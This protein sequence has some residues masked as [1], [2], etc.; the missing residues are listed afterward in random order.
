M[1]QTHI[2][3]KLPFRKSACFVLLLA[4][5]LSASHAGTL[6][7][8]QL[9]TGYALPQEGLLPEVPASPFPQLQATKG[10]NLMSLS[11]SD[12]GSATDLTPE[13]TALAISL[14]SDPYSIFNYVRNK[15]EYQPYWGSHKGA[16]GTYLDGAGNDMDQCSLLIALLNA[17]GYTQTSYVRGNIN[18]PVTTGSLHDLV[19]WYGTS[20][21]LAPVV[22]SAAGIPY[23]SPLVLSG[24]TSFD[25]IW[26]RVVIDGTTYDLDP[27]YK[28]IQQYAGI[29]YK[30]ASGY[31]RAQLLTDAAGTEGADFVQDMNRASVESSLG[32]YAQNLRSY[33]QTNVPSY[34]FEQVVASGTLFEESVGSL[35]AGAPRSGFGP[36]V[37]SVFTTIPDALRGSLHVQTGDLDVTMP[38]DA[39]QARPLALTFSGNNA[40]LWL[41]GTVI[42]E[43]TAGGGPTAMVNINT[44]H[45]VSRLSSSPSGKSYL[46]TGTYDL[47]YAFYPNPKSNGRIEAANRRLAG[48]LAAGLADTS[49]EVLTETL[50]GLGLRWVKRAALGLQMTSRVTNCYGWVD[51]IF[52]RTGQEASFFVDMYGGVSNIFNSEGP[53]LPAFSAQGFLASAMEHGVIE[54]RATSSAL[55]T[56][57]CLALANDGGQK[58]Y[59]ATTNNFSTISPALLA[60]GYTPDDVAWISSYVTAAGS[61]GATLVH[62]NGQ[63][64]TGE[65]LG[66]GFSSLGGSFVSMMIFG[67][68]HGGYFSL[69]GFIL[70]GQFYPLSTLLGY[71]EPF[72][73]AK[74]MSK[75][76]VDL[77]T[78]AYTM[79]STDLSL[80]EA[81]SPRGLAFTRTY[82]SSRNFQPSALGNGWRHSCEG[83][84]IVGSDLD[85]AFGYRQASDAV[86]TIVGVIAAADFSKAAYTAKEQM[87]GIL[88]ANWLVNRITNNSATVQLG[89]HRLSYTSLP[90]GS[91]NSPPGAT[92]TLTGSS[93]SFVLQPRFGGSVSFDAQN[94]VS[95]W[96]DVDDN[97]QTYTYDADGRLET[98]TDSQNRALTFSYFSASSPLIQSVSD[99]TGRTVTY[100]HTGD[101][102]TGIQDVEGYNTTLVYD[103][104][105]LLKDW[106]D[107]AGNFITR[108]NYDSEDRVIQQISQGDVNR[109]W[110]FFYSPGVTR[111]VDPLNY[112]TTHY[113]DSKN[114]PWGIVD[115]RGNAS[116][117]SYDGQNHVIKTVDGSGRQTQFIYDANQN[118]I[119]TTDNATKTTSRIYDG[120]L[121]LW[122]IIDPTSRVTEFGYDSEHHLTSIKDP[123]GRVTQMT[124]NAD[125]RLHLVTDP[126]NKTTAFTSYDQWANPTGVTRADS[127]TTS[128]VF[129]ARGDMTSLTNGRG[130]TIGFTYDNRRLL[131]TR[132]DPLNKVSSWTYDS[133]GRPATATDRNSKTTT[134]V[135]D[136]FGKLQSVAAPDTGTVNFGY[137]LR[138]L[139]TTVSDGLAHTTTTG[140]DAASRPQTVTD[141][142][143]IVVSTV[144]L[145]GAAR[146]TQRKNGLNKTTQ[147]F[148]DSAGRISYM[149][150]P[151]NRR[152]DSTYDD[153]G[154][155]LTLKNRNN[156]TFAY[157]IGSD[158]LP[159]TFT[160]PSGRQSSIVDRDLAGRP[161][162]LQKPGGQQTVLTYDGMGRVKTQADGVGTIT[163]TY[164]V[165]GNPTNVAEGTANIGRT[166][167][168]LGRVLTCTDTAG[169]TVSYTYD[170]EGNLATL[171][172]P[173]NKTVSYTYDGS[174]RLK[175]V[176]D[177]AGRLTTYTWDLGGRL[178]QVDRPNGTRQ[179]LQ[180][181]NANR[182]TD[183][184]EEK[185]ATSIWQAAYG[186]DNAYRL[187]NYTPTPITKTLPPPP[188]TMTYDTDNR[189]Q[190]YNSQTVAN[191]T[192]GNLLSAPVSGTLLGA[193]TW[194]ARNRL[195]SAGEF[196]YAYDAENRRISS[197]ENN[198]LIIYTWSRGGLDRLLVKTNPDGSVTRY[199]H[200]LGLIYE[201]TT[202]SGGGTP[203]PLYYHYN[204]QGS[205]VVLSDASGNV[206]ARI[207]YSPYGE[208][209][210]ESGNVTTPFC[211]N[212]QFG[213]MTESSGL[214]AMQAR[215]YS[216]IFRRFLS[217]DPAGFGGG[218]N[219]YA[220]T[221]GDP[222]NL[223]DPFGLGP[224][225]T[226]EY[227]AGVGQV[228][229][230]YGDA[231]TE[232]VMGLWA[233]VRNPVGT[234]QGL[235]YAGM[236]P[237][238]TVSNIAGAVGR[239][240][241][242]LG[243]GDN[244]LTG[245]SVGRGLILALTVAAPAA[246]ARSLILA[247]SGVPST[248][249]RVVDARFVNSP[250]LGAPGAADVFVTSASDIAG[251]N[252]SQGL[253][254]RLTLLDN[255]GNLRQGPFGVIQFN[256]P[257]S[258]LAS[259]VF[260]NTPGFIQGGL[261][262]GGASEF[263][264]PNFRINQLQNVTTRTIP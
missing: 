45:P 232:T 164:D 26:V 184:I 176:T 112:V 42:A 127:T 108:N 93:G 228:W 30:G 218:I 177:W 128:A 224:S 23:V 10:A 88:S 81:N 233:M 133:N 85:S 105:N 25:H 137:D 1:N 244:R 109:L 98:V 91:W 144:V 221:G 11:L 51:G 229:R 236:H 140:Y 74:D 115:A 102:L 64:G 86:Q 69:R 245:R 5:F 66:Y 173:G 78:G 250:T 15:V 92:T 126:A 241:Q 130:K 61:F 82:D 212:G 89:E 162:T 259:P 193:L 136:N 57:K 253:A 17:A 48:F 237:L 213:V 44:T 143:S 117:I 204:W 181:D 194:D 14:R 62:E 94:R 97:T 104:R 27:S 239:T 192:N 4:G 132:T 80:G 151:L 43:E 63:T 165:E 83:R 7:G 18:V 234:A 256:M 252:T 99:G 24:W 171:T 116:S 219:L 189:L 55:S 67:D 199:I 174:N 52:G 258:G 223:M 188:A 203:A 41:G 170:N 214:L 12:F 32:Q 60:N 39:L 107:H 19:R 8:W 157:G 129:N 9:G 196:A 53:N 211:F 122:K 49:R 142:L 201:E 249:A 216:P 191:D 262:R 71:E 50:H 172:Y 141:P 77:A 75:E 235:Y 103:S 257:A 167:D 111:E 152:V 175:T 195:T 220:Y 118:L 149:L 34:T 95:H 16:H 161:H 226:G 145:D 158:G 120:S 139:Q 135:F 205:T 47:T 2:L 169:N 153:A 255:A 20:S 163:W 160:Y 147:I 248:L 3:A 101:N 240:L 56:V 90:D 197:T 13:L 73:V 33:I 29:D 148:Y 36:T 222:V 206:T 38:T 180:Y 22:I 6:P 202:P 54:E 264:L 125:G 251:I 40:Q 156:Q 150:D 146:V 28:R 87:T 217:E 124:Y 231:G 96:K 210:V 168:D 242:D 21:S 227:I 84:V 106:K 178:T 70:G 238:Q 65:W 119:Y 190:T 263:A 76:P 31:N 254:N 121:R 208:R 179:R 58:I 247:E 225:A 68:Y 110:R 46:R 154:R 182:L 200:G 37:S 260:R 230:G 209:T 261:T 198:Q 59:R 215:Y 134:T 100:S 123:G 246:K 185:G 72:G 243:S 183:T 207:S 166:F 79:A 186:Y 187:T 113:F 155:Q 159:T 138:D 114:R 35:A 131:K